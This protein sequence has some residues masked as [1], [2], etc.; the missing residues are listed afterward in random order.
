MTTAVTANNNNAN[1][2]QF[3]MMPYELLNIHHVNGQRFDLN[4]KVVYQYI[5]G[6][7]DNGQLAYFSRA[8]LGAMLGIEVKAVSKVINKL[9]TLGLVDRIER[10]GYTNLYIVN[11]VN[12]SA[13]V[14]PVLEVKNESDPTVGNTA[15]IIDYPTDP[16]ESPVEAVEPAQPVGSGDCNSTNIEPPVNAPVNAAELVELLEE[17]E[18]DFYAYSAMTAPVSTSGWVTVNNNT[19]LLRAAYAA[20][21]ETQG[22]TLTPEYDAGEAF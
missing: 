9:I 17:E 22:H 15:S 13:N 10:P 21:R 4:M 19:N 16:S 3:L 7:Q 20:H 5:K 18:P 1:N 11:P 6:F 14:A 2:Q 8:K 12:P